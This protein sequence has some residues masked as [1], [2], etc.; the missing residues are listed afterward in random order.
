MFSFIDQPKLVCFE[1]D[2][3]LVPKNLVQRQAVNPLLTRP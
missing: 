2:L 1:A 3:V